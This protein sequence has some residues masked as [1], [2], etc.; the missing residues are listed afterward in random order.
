LARLRVENLALA[1]AYQVLLEPLSFEVAAGESIAITGP[2]GSGKTLLLRLLN[3][4]A[5]PTGGT[6]YLDDRDYRQWPAPQLRQRL[7]LVAAPHLLDMNVQDALLYP[8]RLQRLSQAVVE[9]RIV[10]LLD[11]WP[12]PESWLTKTAAQLTPAACQIVSIGRALIAEPP[13][14]LLDEPQQLL[15]RELL[16]QLRTIA[17]QQGMALM[18]AGK[19]LAA[20]RYLYL[21]RGQ[22]QWDRPGVDWPT[23]MDA[24]A[25][26]DRAANA[27]W[28]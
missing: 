22:L 6:V 25:A 9:Q 20:D 3:R 12:I 18:M 1:L 8:L 23:L 24:M 21:E 26:A 16:T 15:D 7:L 27:D 2:S 19:E 5:E 17:Q 4:L 10:K 11:H 14:L 13:V 28:E